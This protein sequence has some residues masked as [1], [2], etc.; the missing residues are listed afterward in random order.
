MAVLTLDALCPMPYALCAIPY[1][2]PTHA[3]HLA[4]RQEV[5]DMQ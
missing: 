1:L 3:R 5:L 4:N 2:R